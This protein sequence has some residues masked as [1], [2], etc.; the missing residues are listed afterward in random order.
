MEDKFIYSN[1]ARKRKSRKNETPE[2]PTSTHRVAAKLN[3]GTT[4]KS[5]HEAAAESRKSNYESV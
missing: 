4:A 1:S 3:H 2:Q 5:S